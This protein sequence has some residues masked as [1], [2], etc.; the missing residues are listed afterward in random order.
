LE[1]FPQF[2]VALLLLAPLPLFPIAPIEVG[3]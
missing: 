3:K 1:L 2:V